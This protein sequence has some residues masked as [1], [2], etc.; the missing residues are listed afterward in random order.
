MI[1]CIAIDDEKWALDLI[2]DNIRQVPYLEL[3]RRCKNSR[4]A[5]DALDAEKIDL[6]FLDI[7]MPGLS[8]LQF[9][10]T[11]P[12]PPMIIFVTAY[13]QY[14]LEGFNVSAVDYL[15]KPVPLERFIK[16]C[17]KAKSIFDLRHRERVGENKPADHFF[18][19]VEYSLVKIV[20]ADIAFIEGYR[21]YIK[22]HLTSAER[23]V[24]TRMSLKAIEETVPASQFARTHK[25]YIVAIPK[26]TSV[27]RDF[28][29]VNEIE[30]PVSE[31]YKDSLEKITG[32]Q[33]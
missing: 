3:V 21:D 14:A 28:V 1:R 6:I 24:L 22:I 31:S 2:A 8:G 32:S 15:V 27:K 20:L 4:E 30:I 11:L 18:V 12:E 7:Q 19:N 33:K 13:E 25:S 9:I 29:C 17:N 26:I 10:Q 16:A 23:P 5:T